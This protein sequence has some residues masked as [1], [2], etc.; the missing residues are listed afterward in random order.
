MNSE[1]RRDQVQD[2]L[3]ES[4]SFILWELT[5]LGPS[6][7]LNMDLKN[8][9]VTRISVLLEGRKTFAEEIIPEHKSLYNVLGKD[10]TEDKL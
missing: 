2:I 10:E 7:L 5:K 4:V 3:L 6:T 9:L 8:N 1:E